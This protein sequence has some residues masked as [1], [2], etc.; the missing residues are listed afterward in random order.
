VGDLKGTQLQE[1]RIEMKKAQETRRHLPK[2]KNLLIIL[3]LLR[4]QSPAMA[5]WRELL[6]RAPSDS[7]EV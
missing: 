5:V 7:N 4:E 3:S 1:K 6:E 2:R